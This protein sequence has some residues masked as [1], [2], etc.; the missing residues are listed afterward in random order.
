MAEK[1]YISNTTGKVVP[2]SYP[3]TTT[4]VNMDAFLRVSKRAEELQDI[5]DS[6]KAINESLHTRNKEPFDALRRYEPTAEQKPEDKPVYKKYFSV[7]KDGR[8]VARCDGYDTSA[9]GMNEII[10]KNAPCTIV[11]YENG[12]EYN[13]MRCDGMECKKGE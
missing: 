12:E 9:N 13:R 8:E 3:N 5:N 4:Y 11:F 10:H 2:E 6:L 7:I 1:I